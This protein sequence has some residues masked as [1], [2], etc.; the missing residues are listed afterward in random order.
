VNADAIAES[1]FGPEAV[2]RL[3]AFER[4][5]HPMLIADDRRRWVTGN[6]AA[7]HLLRVA[8]EEIPWRTMDDFTPPGER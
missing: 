1:R 7:C 5:Q 2:I 3:R 4:S 6:A 8:R